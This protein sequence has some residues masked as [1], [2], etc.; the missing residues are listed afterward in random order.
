MKIAL[1]GF[2]AAGIGFVK[3]LVDS[4]KILETSIDIYERGKDIEHSGF[5]GLKYDG[6]IF[7]SRHMGGDLEL[8]LDVQKSVVKFFLEYAEMDTQELQNL[9]YDDISFGNTELYKAFYSQGF[10]PIRSKFFHIG[11]DILKNVVERI[12]RKFS[13]YKNI[14]FKFGES[15]ED[16]Q[17][18]EDKVVVIT[19]AKSEEYD[20]VVVAVGRSGFRLVNKLIERYPQLVLTNT[21]VDL[22]V[23]YELPNHIVEELNKQM[24]EFKVRLKT[25]TGYIARTFCNNPAGEV[26]LEEYEDFVTVN[27]HAKSYKQTE[28]T[29]FAILV[30]HNFT[31]PF[32]DPVGYGMYIAKLANILAG[33]RKVILQCFEDFK[34]SKRTKK[35]GRVHPTLEPKNFILGDLNLV[36]PRKTTESIIDFI[37]RLDKVVPGVAAP[38]NL[39]Y[40]VEVKFYGNKINNEF[41]D[42]LKIIG[43]CSGWTR[44]ITYAAGHG[45]LVAQNI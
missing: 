26:T 20:K 30:T 38:D 3:G 22:G 24:Y 27:G 41:S 43:D 17:L 7:I 37:E 25:R 15:V 40:G 33:G 12:Y 9:S 42:K 23:R 18:K 35:I 5:G 21:Q 1:I 2:G 11:T 16:T 31:E 32:N 14:N 36:L 44:S 4:G 13:E 45:Y 19:K 8:P 39:M 28:N 34:E 6:K 10:E 29:N